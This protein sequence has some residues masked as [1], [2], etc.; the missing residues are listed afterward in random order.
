[1]PEPGVL[2]LDVLLA[3]ISEDAPAGEDLLYSGLHSEIKE[4][5]RSDDDLN[6]GDWKRDLKTA[7]WDKVESLATDALRSKTKDLQ[8][9]A[10]LTEAA[11][12]L[13]GLPGLRDGLHLEKGLID[14]FWE[15]LFPENED[16][17]LEARANCLAWLDK[18]ATPGIGALVVTGP[19]T[20][21]FTFL[22]WQWASTPDPPPT[23]QQRKNSDTMRE[24][25]AVREEKEKTLAEIQKAISQSPGPF[26][27]QYAAASKE[28]LEAFRELDH[29]IDER[30]GRQAPALLEMKKA[31]EDITSMM[32]K[33]AKEK[34]AASPEASDAAVGGGVM[35]PAVAG[36]TAAVGG[37]GGG[38]SVAGAIASR[39][40]ALRRLTEIAGYFEKT[41]P[42]SPVSYLVN[43]AVAWGNMPLDKWLRDVVKD[44]SVLAGIRETLGIKEDESYS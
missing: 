22:K 29:A 3:P 41:E 35:G 24:L 43:R 38:F 44:D 12:R 15:G 9:G 39:Q 23:E 8:I 4:A 20:E 17:D 28:A 11:L 10:W 19:G 7:D 31:L 27:E 16:G 5:R 6:Q 36:A 14:K 32:E 18:N 33:L 25:D 40:E 21:P 13:Y 42:H 2:D 30:F 37:G 26:Y 34:R 1:M